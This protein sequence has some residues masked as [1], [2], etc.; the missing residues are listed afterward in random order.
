MR[1]IKFRAW[2]K[3]QQRILEMTIG[4]DYVPHFLN[5][6]KAFGGGYINL[7]DPDIEL[8]QFTGLKDKNGKEIYEGDMVKTKQEIQP[9]M[10]NPNRKIL[11]EGIGEIKWG[12]TGWIIPMPSF[13]G[14][15]WL[16]T[17]DA[18]IIFDPIGIEKEVIGNVFENPELLK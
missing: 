10:T 18:T 11:V 9:D 2:H 1:E 3:G 13:K 5:D 17:T 8:M 14:K 16:M 12:G 4:T 6:V 15:E 7:F